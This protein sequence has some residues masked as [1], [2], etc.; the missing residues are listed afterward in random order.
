[1]W[2]LD[3]QWGR[4]SG[5]LLR[6]FCMAPTLAALVVVHRRVPTVAREDCLSGSDDSAV[7]PDVARCTVRVH[8]LRGPLLSTADARATSIHRRSRGS[9]CALI[10]VGGTPA[11]RRT[12][13][14]TSSSSELVAI[15]RIE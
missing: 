12:R 5:R 8:A 6:E 11:S 1:M 2:H 14:A 7:G 10:R 3:A 4:G 15:A 13:V 9:V